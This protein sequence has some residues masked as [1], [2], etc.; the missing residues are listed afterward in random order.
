[1]QAATVRYY[2]LLDCLLERVHDLL[3]RLPG[4]HT[5]GVNVATRWVVD[6]RGSVVDFERPHL[7]AALRRSRPDTK[8]VNLFAEGV[9]RYKGKDLDVR[10]VLADFVANRNRHSMRGSLSKVE[11]AVRWHVAGALRSGLPAL[12]HL[13]ACGWPR[14]VV[15]AGR[16]K[17]P[18]PAEPAGI[19][20]WAREQAE[21]WAA[22]LR[23]RA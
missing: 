12:S 6:D 3:N 22:A 4:R 1:M 8:N 20:P 2:A 9:S 18:A 16:R 14:D 21:Q 13:A 23:Q 7:E 15:N 11:G 10:F 19:R 17:E 5:V